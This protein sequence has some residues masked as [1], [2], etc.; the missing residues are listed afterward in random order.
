M[1]SSGSNPFSTRFIQ[2]GRIPWLE[3]HYRLDSLAQRWQACGRRAAIVGPHGAGKSTLL[4][5]LVPL[6]GQTQVRRNAE[7]ETLFDRPATNE[8]AALPPLIWLQLRRSNPQSLQIP[9]QRWTA[10]TTLVLDGYE[11]LPRWR[12][13]AVCFNSVLRCNYLLITSHQKTLLSTLCRVEV[14]GVLARRIVAQ[15]LS[16]RPDYPVPSQ[17]A[18]DEALQRHRGSLRE[19]LMELY[20]QYE[21]ARIPQR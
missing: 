9:W 3:T 1:R 12:R 4:E 2:P 20:D 21:I 17:V 15:L 16:E 11:Q 13:L 19:V 14:D 8:Q 6:I 7:G 18:L 5:S 10:G